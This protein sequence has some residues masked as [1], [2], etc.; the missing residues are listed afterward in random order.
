M[1]KYIWRG[2]TY[3]I[4]EEDLGR[5]PGAIPVEPEKPAVEPERP[6]ATE[7]KAES[8]AKEAP[9]NKSRQKKPANK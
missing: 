7:K 3:Q 8:K 1:K 5:Y 9:K 6:K 2:V 4:A